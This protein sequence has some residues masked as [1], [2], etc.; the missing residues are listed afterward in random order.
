MRGRCSARTSCDAISGVFDAAEQPPSK[1]A[2][3]SLR[4][5]LAAHAAEPG[6]AANL[7]CLGPR[8]RHARNL[9]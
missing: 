7:R 9:A 3:C 8:L 5:Q 1:G 4:A 6:T 2:S